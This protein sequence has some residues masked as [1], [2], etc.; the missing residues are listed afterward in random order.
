M[1]RLSLLKNVDILQASIAKA[2]VDG[3]DLRSF[4]T[5]FPLEYLRLL[6]I[7]S[8]LNAAHVEMYEL[9]AVLKQYIEVSDDH[10]P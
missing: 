10:K 4:Q 8:H 9:K 3:E 2:L 1:D 6:S 5:E 7:R